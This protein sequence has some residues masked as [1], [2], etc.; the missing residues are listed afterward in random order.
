[1]EHQTSSISS[2]SADPV[3]G[4]GIDE[5]DNIAKKVH[6][7]AGYGETPNRC[8]LQYN[9]DISDGFVSES[10]LYRRKVVDSPDF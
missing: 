1:M 9:L 5:Y 2:A 7:D 4:G 6:W 10:S 3:R 8:G